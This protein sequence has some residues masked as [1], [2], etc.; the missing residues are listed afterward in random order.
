MRGCRPSRWHGSLFDSQVGFAVRRVCS[1]LLD[2]PVH[3]PADDYLARRT[4]LGADEVNR[5]LIRPTGISEF[6]VDTGYLGDTVTSPAE[7]GQLAAATAQR[8]VRLE[9]VAESVV[10][11][12]SAEGFA[13]AYSAALRDAAAGAVGLKSIAAYRVGLDLDPPAPGCARGGGRRGAVGRRIE[14]GAP[15]RM[16]D[17]C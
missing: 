8:I 16:A 10:T 15:P 4:A 2:L 14:A 6:L 11:T 13:D 9:T 17:E 1:P 7:L 12:C 5:R 3:A